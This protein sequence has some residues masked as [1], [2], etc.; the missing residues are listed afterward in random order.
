MNSICLSQRARRNRRTSLIRQMLSET[1]LSPMDF[2][3]PLFVTAGEKSQIPSMPKVYR[4]PVDSLLKEVSQAVSLGIPAV[5][6]FPVLEDSLKDD[7]AS[8][9]TNPQGLLQQAIQL[10]K[11]KYPQLC[12]ISDV[13]MDPYTPQGHDGLVR[14]GRVLNDETLPILARMAIQQARAGADYVAPSDMMDG[15][16]GYIRQAL[17]EEGWSEVG[18]LSYAVKYAS[19]LY[20]PFREALD[21]SPQGDKETYQMDPANGTEALREVDLDQREGADILMVKP[22][23]AYLDII[24]RVRSRICLPVAAYHVSGEYAMIKA[25]GERGWIDGEK[26]SLEVHLAMKRAGADVIF[27]YSA[28]DL[29]KALDV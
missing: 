2:V 12:V 14:E 4:H 8:E 23:L 20:S 26:V 3:L 19:S 5:A 24:A 25:A 21:S 1:T 9:S 11:N 15:R 6:L 7:Q 29:A 17:D 18:I 22:A 13:A 27:T 10:L 28:M 16:V